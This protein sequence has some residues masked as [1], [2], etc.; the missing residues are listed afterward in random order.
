[1]RKFIHAAA[2]LGAFSTPTAAVDAQTAPTPANGEIA[3]VDAAAGKITMRHGPIRNLDMD[4]MTMVFRAGDPA[5][6]TAVK[7][8]D[9]V[10]FEAE[11]VNG[12][13]TITKMRKAP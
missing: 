1:M 4:S 12:Q 9:K 7:P 8:G 10:V 3:K 11:R 6:L 13:I 2:V 5:M